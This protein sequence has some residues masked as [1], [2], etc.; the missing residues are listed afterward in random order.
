MLLSSEHRDIVGHSKRLFRLM[1]GQNDGKSISRQL[2]NPVQDE[3]AIAEVE[4]GRRLVHNNDV[5]L[6][7]EGARNQCKLPL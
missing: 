7:R 4:A 6:L 5:G 1:R 2:A 3:Q